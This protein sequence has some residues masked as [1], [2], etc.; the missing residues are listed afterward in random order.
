MDKFEILLATL[1]F[2]LLMLT[3]TVILINMYELKF[4]KSSSCTEEI[5]I[6]DKYHY[7]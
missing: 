7:K 2:A 3:N 1:A 6:T 4:P 5:N